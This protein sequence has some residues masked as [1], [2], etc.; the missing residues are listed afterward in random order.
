MTRIESQVSAVRR[1]LTLDVFL[2]Y[3]CISAFVLAA[4]GLLVIISQKFFHFG[5]PPLALWIGLGVMGIAALVCTFLRAPSRGFAAVALDEKLG[6]KEKMSTALALGSKRSQDPFIDAMVRDAEQTAAG[7]QLSGQFPL[8]FPRMGY[9]AIGTAIVAAL[10]L[11]FIPQINLF[12]KPDDPIRKF[13]PQREMADGRK[14]A[15][16]ALLKLEALP[17]EA[18]N[19]KDVQIAKAQLD[20]LMKAPMA[21]REATA[22]RVAEAL[23][24]AE[25]G[26]NKAVQENKDY[27]QAKAADKLFK[28]INTPIDGT[29]PVADAQRK[30]VKGDYEEA[31]KDIEKAIKAFENGSKKEQ[32]ETAK[33]VNQLAQQLQQISQDKQAEEKLQKQ[34]QQMGV[35]QQQIQQAQNL[36]K[37]AAQGGKQA[38]QQVQQAMQ[39]MAQGL[40]QQQ[41]QQLQQAMQQAAQAANAQAQAQNMGQAAQQMAQAMA[42]AAQAQQG[43][44][45]N[46]ANQQANQQQM[47][48]Q[49]QNLQQQLQQMQAAANDAR[50]MQAAQ[51]QMQQAMQQAAGQCQGGP[52][53]GQGDKPGM[54]NQGQWAQGDPENNPGNG[55]GGPG[56]GAGGNTG[57]T[58]APF[59]TKTEVSKSAYDEKGKHLASI[60]VKD[61]SVRGEAK[62]QLKEAIEAG[63]ADA[64]DDIDESRVDRRTQEAVRRYFETM[65]ND[66]K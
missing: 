33:Q 50:Q 34:L 44:Q 46:P 15:Q 9:F 58:V 54:G 64:G 29:G 16:D 17:K 66:T 1:K 39:Q 20:Q 59:S 26:L 18:A 63:Q 13:D 14:L 3:L 40:N 36:I 43:N 22:R 42:Q 10:S 27:A 56:Q 62:L 55:Q 4:A 37:Q 65:K 23:E 28:S 12:D 32:E 61:R 19:T 21:T 49:M 30:L 57:K 31:M 24:Q 48:Q 5:L 47:Q 7:V 35:N 51:Q 41:Q 38:Q 8:T 6:L 53:D 52:G 25:K 60:Y 11:K 45:Q 2:Q